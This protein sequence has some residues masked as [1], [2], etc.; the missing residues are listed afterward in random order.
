MAPQPGARLAINN[1]ARARALI[2]QLLLARARARRRSISSIRTGFSSTASRCAPRCF[3]ADLRPICCIVRGSSVREIY[4]VKVLVCTGTGMKSEFSGV[5]RERNSR[6]G[7][8]QGIRGLW[9]QGFF[10]A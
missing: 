9:V 10:S 4:F 2:A 5:L 8:G 3:R 7:M 1:P 6:F